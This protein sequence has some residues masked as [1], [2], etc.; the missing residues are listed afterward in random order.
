MKKRFCA[1]CAILVI[2]IG[3]IASCSRDPKDQVQNVIEEW[4]TA[5]KNG[6]SGTQYWKDS[7]LEKRF[8]AVRS[9]QILAVNYEPSFPDNISATIRVESSN[10]GGSPIVTDWTVYLDRTGN[11]WKI[12]LLIPH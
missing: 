6:R 1:R 8:F 9:Y 3:L 10:K 2:L 12:T 5:L 4:L 11:G 7:N